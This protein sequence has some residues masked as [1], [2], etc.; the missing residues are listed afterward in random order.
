MGYI[1]LNLSGVRYG[2]KARSQTVVRGGPQ[3]GKA[4]ALRGQIRWFSVGGMRLA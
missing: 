4:F 3:L 2:K 1:A